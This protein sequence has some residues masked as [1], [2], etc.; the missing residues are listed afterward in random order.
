MYAA[1]LL[2]A[3]LFYSFFTAVEVKQEFQMEL[4]QMA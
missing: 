3:E 2:H 1:W 4:G